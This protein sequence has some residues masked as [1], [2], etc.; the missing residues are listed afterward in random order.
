MHSHYVPCTVNMAVDMLIGPILILLE[1]TVYESVSEL[2][3]ALILFFTV[4][5]VA[6]LFKSM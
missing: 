3:S 5:G 4:Q 6:L 1:F 2:M